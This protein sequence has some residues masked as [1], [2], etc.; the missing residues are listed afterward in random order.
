M[1]ELILVVDDEERMRKLIGAYLK[2]ERYQVLEA[3][4]GMDA[5]RIF[6]ENKIH[7][8]VLDVMMPVM[9]GW[10]TCTELRKISNVPIVFLTA[11]SEDDDKLLG[12]ELGTDHYVTKP[13]NMKLLIAKI[14]NLI[15][16]AYYEKVDVKKELYF[17]GLLINE[18]SH[19]VTINGEEINLSPKEYDL[20][21][22]FAHNEKI[23]LSREKILDKV[24]GIDFIGELRTA[25]TYIKRL[26]EKLGDRAYLVSTV[27]GTG[28]KF[29]AKNEI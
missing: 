18:L 25:D 11:K 29:E 3:E 6:K 20:L 13:F 8:V 17:D 19:S 4:N 15:N 10:T 27:R 24:W 16:R 5:L 9:D 12:Y 14:E 2:K 1:K 21:V 7:L 26:R 28:Y 23:V 22:Y